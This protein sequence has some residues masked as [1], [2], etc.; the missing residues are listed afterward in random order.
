MALQCSLHC[1]LWVFCVSNH[2]CCVQ[3]Q[4]R[5]EREAKVK[6]E[7]DAAKAE[8]E[9]REEEEKALKAL[10]AKAHKAPARPAETDFEEEIT[11][12]AAAIQLDQQEKILASL[13]RMHKRA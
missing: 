10:R 5:E 12:T 6:A 3:R 1:N 9:K 11:I 8:L 13:N 4:A 7:A 2:V